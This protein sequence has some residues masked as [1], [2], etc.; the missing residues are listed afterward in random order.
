VFDFQNQL[1]NKRFTLNKKQLIG[2]GLHPRIDSRWTNC[3]L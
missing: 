1:K 3:W 2:G